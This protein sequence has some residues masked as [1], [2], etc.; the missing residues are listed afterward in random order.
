MNSVI[1]VYTFL[2]IPGSSA[3]YSFMAMSTAMYLGVLQPMQPSKLYSIS[4]VLY[5]PLYSHAV[6]LQMLSVGANHTHDKSSFGVIH[7]SYRHLKTQS[8]RYP[9]HACIYVATYK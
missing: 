8:C 6:F 7:N 5:T 4:L 3:V 2:F 9:S 1:S